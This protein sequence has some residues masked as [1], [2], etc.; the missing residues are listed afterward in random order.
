MPMDSTSEAHGL[1]GA[2]MDEPV[3]TIA[4]PASEGSVVSVAT[5]ASEVVNL[6]P[7]TE[8]SVVSVATSASEVVS[9]ERPPITSPSASEMTGDQKAVQE[10][11]WHKVFN[12]IAR[13]NELAPRNEFHPPPASKLLK[14]MIACD[15]WARYQAIKEGLSDEQTD[16]LSSGMAVLRSTSPTRGHYSHKDKARWKRNE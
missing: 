13:G 6:R 9:S 10:A 11:K 14:D 12:A 15:V 2:S 8:G 5:S 7:V 1:Q 3:S 16:A 4:P